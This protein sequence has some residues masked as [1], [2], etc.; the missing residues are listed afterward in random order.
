VNR[1]ECMFLFDNTVA[2]EWS[3]VQQEVQRLFERIG[4][5][6]LACVKFDERKLAYEIRGRKRGTYVLTYVDAPGER[7][8]EFERDAQLSESVLRVL[9][10]R[11]DGPTP[12]RLAELAAWPVDK[13]LSP[14]ADV[15]RDDRGD[16]RF[17]GRRDSW[18]RDDRRDGGR[19][20]E[21]RGET[22][23]APVG[24]KGDGAEEQ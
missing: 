24:D 21:R 11:T 14:L 3:A 5:S 12:E 9:I 6:M 18:R 7:I 17:E 22:A 4:A 8:G 2:H 16:G 20:D 15:R 19:P 10:L 1:Y 13:P 23:E